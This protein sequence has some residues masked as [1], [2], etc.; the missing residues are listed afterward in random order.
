MI[1]TKQPTRPK[2]L[3]LWERVYLFEI[4]RGLWITIRHFLDNFIHM[5][6]RMTVE[7]PEQ[8]KDIPF[9]YRA[10]HRLMLRANGDVRCTACM[11]CA[12]ACPS[13]CIKIVAEEAPDRMIEK[14]PKEYEIDLLRCVFC[15]LCVEACPCDAIRM[16]TYKY[17]NANCNRKDFIYDKGKLLTNHAPGQSP[18]SV[19]L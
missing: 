6:T 13:D 12:T 2:K 9:G 10:E 5:K 18:Y 17:E 11:L 14:R 8:K 15:G 4:I 1:T 3:T 19:A 16:D 7:Y